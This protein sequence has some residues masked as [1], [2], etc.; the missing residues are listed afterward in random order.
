MQQTFGR[1]VAELL[2]NHPKHVGFNGLKLK[3]RSVR[4][5]T[6]TF[7]ALGSATFERLGQQATFFGQWLPCTRSHLANCR[8]IRIPRDNVTTIG[9]L[10]RRRVIASFDP[11]SLMNSVKLRVKRSTEHVKRE[12]GNFWANR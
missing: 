12:F 6:A 7:H 9:D 8:T 1:S 3:M 4:N 5:A 11:T 2:L 10:D